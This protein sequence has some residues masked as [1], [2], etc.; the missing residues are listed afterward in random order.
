MNGKQK[1]GAVLALAA[2]GLFSALPSTGSEAAPPAADVH[3]YGVN[4]CKGQNDCGTETNSCKGEG[5]C[6]GKG[7]VTK[8][9]AQECEDAGGTVGK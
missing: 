6:K 1:T 9:S 3:C 7:W 2:A 5:S 4:A 8:P